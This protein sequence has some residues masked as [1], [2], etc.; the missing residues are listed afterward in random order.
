MRAFT[1]LIYIVVALTA[2]SAEA[3][4]LAD[5]DPF[6]YEVKFTNPECALY[7][8]RRPVMSVAGDRL[9]A[10]PRHA[11]C[12]TSDAAASGDRPSSPQYKLTE[13]IRD[14]ATQEIFF[15]YL[16]FSN[17]KIRDELCRAIE[18]R[19]VKVRFVLDRGTQL[20][21]AN[22]LLKCVPLSGRPE[23]KPELFL[24]GQSGNLGFAH[25]KVFLVNPQDK[26]R[27]G[28]AF[29]SGNLS[30]GTV[31]HHE[32]WHFITTAPA[33][34]FA[35]THLCLMRGMLE[36]GEARGQ[37]SN[38]VRSCRNAIAAPEEEDI[39]V[40][41]V[42]GEGGAASRLLQEAVK[43]SD[44][45]FIAA[46]RFSY[47]KL[48]RA[49]KERLQNEY[50]VD[51]RVLVDD[52]IYWAGRGEPTGANTRPEFE[53]VDGLRQAGAYIR[54]METNHGISQFHHNKFILFRGERF[55]GLFTGAGNLT[56]AAF[57]SNFENFYFIT[58]PQ[59]LEEFDRQY[60]HL[61]DGLATKPQ[62]MPRENV[63]P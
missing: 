53:N 54:Y 8:Y 15:A 12:K 24:R 34:Y 1:I 4:R 10:K 26:N 38:F 31:L 28:I 45:V 61:W 19:D 36:A 11:Y 13:W 17:N 41:L 39:K 7:E 27:L 42:P 32:N 48:L 18:E 22:E 35:Q 50:P 43:R 9:T 44:G 62:N 14:P 63:L 6:A 23:R 51:M 52:D 30:A 59:V 3:K 21:D 60:D 5:Y 47:G 33:S 29:S 37:Y 25:N 55:S 2:P 58:I 16:S 56:T 57:E 49:L 46:H 20:E 40:F